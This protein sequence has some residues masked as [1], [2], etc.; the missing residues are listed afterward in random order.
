MSNNIQI[1][2][3]NNNNSFETNSKKDSQE[4]VIN[5]LKSQY[6]FFNRINRNWFVIQYLCSFLHKNPN[7]N[8]KEI[9]LLGCNMNDD[10]LFILTRTLLDHEINILILN[11]SVKKI[12]DVSASNILDI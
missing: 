10:D 11:L 5:Q 1:N 9:K 8:Y 2:N 6:H 3:N 4:I 7:Y 12:T